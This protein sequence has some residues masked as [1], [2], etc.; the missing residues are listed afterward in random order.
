MA[1]PALEFDMLVELKEHL[2]KLLDEHVSELNSLVDIKLAYKKAGRLAE[3]EKVEER[4]KVL[5]GYQN[6]ERNFISFLTHY[7]RLKKE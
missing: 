2:V 4:M 3:Q 1:V 7:L 6:K 5:K